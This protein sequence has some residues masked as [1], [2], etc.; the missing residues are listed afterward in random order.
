MTLRVRMAATA[1]GA[2][3]VVVVAIAA[4]VYLAVRSD[5]RGEVDRVLAQQAQPLVANNVGVA[6]GEAGFSTATGPATP[7]TLPPKAK[8]K[9]GALTGPGAAGK[10]A[11]PAGA[12][13]VA[14]TQGPPQPFTGA[15]GFIQFLG[16]S[17][18]VAK[19][20]NEGLL[21]NIPASPAMRAIAAGGVGRDLVDIRVGGE[22]MR[23]LTLGVGP[24]G[25]V[26]LAQ[27][28]TEVDHELGDLVVI[29]LV[30]GGAGILAAALLGA[31]VART[32]LAP[33]ARF[34][35]RTES[36]AASG[37]ATE[38]LPVAGSDELGRLAASFNRTLEELERSVAAQRQLV[39]DASHELR[40]PIASLRANIQVLEQAERLPAGEREALRRDVVDELDELTGLVGDL[41]ELARG[42]EPAALVDEVRLDQVVS[43]AVARTERRSR[44]ASFHVEIE[45]TVIAGDA[46]RI[47][48]AVAN[49]LDNAVKWSPD[50]GVVD[51]T[52][53]GG[54]LTVGDRGPGF[55]EADLPQIFTRF[56]RADAARGKP[57][58]G[59]GLAIVRQAAEAHGGRAVAA[60]APGG[61]A[62]LTVTFGAATELLR[63]PDVGL[64]HA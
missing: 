34:T 5:L 44:G 64:T 37:E 13:G 57:G 42:A 35:R 53:R 24:A 30:V 58:S 56:Y 7:L 3:A 28:L 25:A 55:A 51:V 32:A 15:G 49:L 6:G 11:L 12:V 63:S 21:P 40:T 62:L 20:A 8:F 38:R 61:G 18:G 41:V 16:A 26:Q 33:I 23:V 14:V 4:V 36:I 54:V 52:L 1:A 47:D 46:P 27:P 50:G 45:P 43:A 31:V 48:R 59:L 22:H 9:A 2:V 60:N 29:L 17:G 10:L 39:A 19:S